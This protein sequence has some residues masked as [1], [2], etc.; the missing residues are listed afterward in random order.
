MQKD[1]SKIVEELGLCPDFTT[2]Y[3]ENKQYLITDTL[4]DMLERLLA[5]S[6][7][8]K[9]AVIKAAEMSEVYGYQIFS[10]LRVPE[11]NKLLCLAVAMKLNID[12][13]QTLL[14]TAG[15][16][17]LYVK[18]PFDSVVL[19]GV[20]KGLSV[21]EINEILYEYGLDTLG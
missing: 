1:T 12:E 9:S 16:S 7:L 14:K 17:P 18:L 6:G 21:I 2:F 8:K 10:G 4:S 20:C 3:N 5:E 11:R 19:Y 13:M 15:Y